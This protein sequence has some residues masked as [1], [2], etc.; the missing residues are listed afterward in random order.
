[1]SDKRRTRS[2]WIFT[3]HLGHL[4]SL[5]DLNSPVIVTRH[6]VNTSPPLARM[7]PRRV[8]QGDFEGKGT[9]AVSAST[10]DRIEFTMTNSCFPRKVRPLS[11]PSP[12]SL[13]SHLM[14][15]IF[16][17]RKQVARENPKKDCFGFSPYRQ[18]PSSVAA[19]AHVILSSNLTYSFSSGRRPAPEKNLAI[20]TMSEDTSEESLCPISSTHAVSTPS[21]TSFSDNPLEKFGKQATGS[22]Q[23]T[24]C[25]S[26]NETSRSQCV[27]CEASRTSGTRP[28][29]EASPRVQTTPCVESKNQ[30]QSPTHTSNTAPTS[31][32]EEQSRKK[33][34]AFREPPEQP[35]DKRRRVVK[36]R[37]PPR[38]QKRKG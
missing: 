17:Q 1:M 2:G 11:E 26:R 4:K 20:C 19:D 29:D 13:P 24:T 33:A 6:S 12:A 36:N 22:W 34:I 30:A 37:R 23:C 31:P 35:L 9:S 28:L 10:R 18:E 5:H 8:V 14:S 3:S 25:M 38:P 7:S 27:C 16:P 21:I 32:V 15:R